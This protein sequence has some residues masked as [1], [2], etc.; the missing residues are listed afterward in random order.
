MTFHDKAALIEALNAMFKPIEDTDF[1]Y[2]LG[3]LDEAI[4]IGDKLA[5]IPIKPA[6]R[7]IVRWFF[8]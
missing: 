2:L 1:N 8:R 5:T 6:K 4:S 7:G 3:R